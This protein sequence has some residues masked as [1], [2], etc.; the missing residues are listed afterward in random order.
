V[1]AFDQPHKRLW[2]ATAILTVML[3][4]I[5]EGFRRDKFNIHYVEISSGIVFDRAEVERLV[6]MRELAARAKAETENGTVV[7]RLK[8]YA[9]TL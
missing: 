1:V 5:P 8:E 3:N 6:E 2:K 9:K 4:P 7:R